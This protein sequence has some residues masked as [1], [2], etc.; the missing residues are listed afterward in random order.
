VATILFA[1][2]V[3]MSCWRI[4]ILQQ[5]E[6]IVSISAAFVKTTMT[7]HSLRA[8]AATGPHG[9]IQPEISMVTRGEQDKSDSIVRSNLSIVIGLVIYASHPLSEPLFSSPGIAKAVTTMIGMVLV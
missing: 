7:Y 6:A 9:E 2:T 1:G 4:S 3:D 5:S 8:M